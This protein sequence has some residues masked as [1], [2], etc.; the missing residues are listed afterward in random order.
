M[1]NVM[2]SSLPLACL[3]AWGCA[4]APATAADTPMRSNAP[5]EATLPAAA[6]V[7]SGSPT[8]ATF[9]ATPPPAMPGRAPQT[10]APF[11]SVLKPATPAVQ[12]PVA[13]PLAP[14]PMIKVTGV[15]VQITQNCQS[16]LP[17]FSAK[18]TLTNAGATAMA[19]KSGSYTL[20][21]NLFLKEVGGISQLGGPPV[22][23]PLLAPG[24]SVTLD[25]IG[26]TLMPY[27]KLGGS[28]QIGVYLTI[29]VWQADHWGFLDNS[30]PAH[31]F[32]VV[33]PPNHCG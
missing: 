12:M 19:A 20:K 22:A 28:H 18:V 10:V 15:G 17:A 3:M 33:Y 13:T 14:P 24:Q 32:Q 7:R 25:A 1:N 9:P 21:Y 29:P 23:I 31:T 8:Q 6:P 27:T 4:G 11:P 2:V 5:V 26:R 30:L 16:P